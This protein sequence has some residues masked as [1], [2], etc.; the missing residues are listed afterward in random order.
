MAWPPE[1]PTPDITNLTEQN[2]RHPD[3]HNQIAVALAELVARAGG[4]QNVSAVNVTQQISIQ[5]NAVV[6]TGTVVN[7]VESVGAVYLIFGSC[8]FSKNGPDTEA[9]CTLW[10]KD[11]SNVDVLISQAATCPAPGNIAIT[12][13]GLYTGVRNGPGYIQLWANTAAGFVNANHRSL[14]IVQLTPT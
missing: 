5:S 2:E 8:S 14:S 3:D 13:S 6:L 1:L 11:Q 12:V 9:A 4:D 7:F 10:I